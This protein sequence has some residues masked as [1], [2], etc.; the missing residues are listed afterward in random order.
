MGET[1]V[2]VSSTQG[3]R[4]RLSFTLD[5]GISGP[6]YMYYRLTNFYQ[7]YRLFAES[8]DDTQLMGETV[9][10]SG[11]SYCDPWDSAGRFRDI[12]DRSTDPATSG[13]P[14]Y[15]S[16]MY[17][18]CGAIA[19]AMFNDSISLYK[20]ADENWAGGATT[21]TSTAPLPNATT[22]VVC[23]GA[24]FAADGTATDAAN[25]N[26]QK[27]DIAV[28]NARNS[29]FKAPKGGNLVWTGE[30]RPSA[31][32]LFLRNGWYA[33]E[34]GHKVPIQTDEDFMV[35]TTLATL[36]DFR[37]LYRIMNVDLQP[38]TYVVEVDEYFDSASYGGEK[39]V[40]LATRSWIGAKNYVLGGLF[41]GLGIWSF[42][43]AV[44]FV[45]QYLIK[46]RK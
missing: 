24:G 39:H 40:I 4:T 3:C 19:W 38:G 8:R 15:G 29:Q 26:C 16:M 5:K 42:V 36:N 10:M 21:S 1:T 31:T 27:K 41:L 28:W 20:V 32:D 35:W 18:P 13:A 33:D 25:T 43:V 2:D 30:G 37:K 7:N 22:T 34:V 17:A 6:V 23:N 11:I 44:A 45:V 12:D 14:T 9:T 46:S